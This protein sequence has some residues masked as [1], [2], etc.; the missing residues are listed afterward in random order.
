M[1]IFNRIV[2]VLLWLLLLVAAIYIALDPVRAAQTLAELATVW[3][4]DL[5]SWRAEN[6]TNYLIAQV[7]FGIGAVVL[8]ALLLWMQLS[9]LRKRGVRIY[10]ADGGAAELDTDSVGRRICWH[11]DQVAEVISVQPTVKP[12]GSAVDIRLE[13]EAAPDVDIPMK[14]E[15]VVQ[16]TREVIE[17]DLGLRMGKL[18]VHMR[19]APFQPDW[20]A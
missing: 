17:N 12:R 11:L 14:T 9:T 10:T 3:A 19:C 18:D 4:D 5:S 8:V 2:V 6:P 16:V 7:A 15:E 20:S 1:V 13:I